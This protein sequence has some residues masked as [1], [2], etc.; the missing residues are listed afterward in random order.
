M[1]ESTEQPKPKTMEEISQD[2][3]RWLSERGVTFKI[4]ALGKRTGQPCAIED[5]LPPTHD[6][7]VTLIRVQK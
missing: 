4:I 6:V 5:F 1:D 7:T 3:E 2:L